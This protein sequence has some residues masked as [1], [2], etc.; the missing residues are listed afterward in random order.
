M[1]KKDQI[2]FLLDHSDST[3]QKRS[4]CRSR[5]FII[6]DL[7]YPSLLVLTLLIALDMRKE[8]DEFE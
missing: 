6:I 3:R 5:A 8:R 2:F 7:P 1:L 4:L